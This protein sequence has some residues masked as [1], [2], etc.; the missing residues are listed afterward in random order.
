MVFSL[1]AL[2]V[3]RAGVQKFKVEHGGPEELNAAP[4]VTRKAA[5]L[6]TELHLLLPKLQTSPSAFPTGVPA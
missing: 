4:K 5:G 3:G 2:A 1:D 6:G